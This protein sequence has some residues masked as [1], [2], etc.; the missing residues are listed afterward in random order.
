VAEEGDLTNIS[1]VRCN[2]VASEHEE[3][4]SYGFHVRRSCHEPTEDFLDVVFNWWNDDL[5]I[6]L[7][8]NVVLHS[9]TSSVWNGT[10]FVQE[11]SK[12][13]DQDGDIG[14]AQL[15][16]QCS[17]VTGFFASQEDTGIDVP[18]RRRRNRMYLG[19]LRASTGVSEGDGRISDA[20][21]LEARSN[22]GDL[23]D[24]LVGSA[25]IGCADSEM[26]GIMVVSFA[27]GKA[28]PARTCRVGK[29]VDTQRRRRSQ[30]PEQPIQG[31]LAN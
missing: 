21:Q 30:W 7:K 18:A 6:T 20:E 17:L 22:I 23:A 5:D 16:P 25:A 8:T 27:E 24:A 19:Y 10:Q 9:V 28:W 14:Q 4:L 2:L 1:L 12:T 29:V 11:A 15:P 26:Q 31:D 3:I 13:Y